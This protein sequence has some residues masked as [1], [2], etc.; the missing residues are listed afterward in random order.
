MLVADG[1]GQRKMHEWIGGRV[2]RGIINYEEFRSVGGLD[3]IVNHNPL[4]DGGIRCHRPLS[5]L[6]SNGINNGAT[7]KLCLLLS[8][9]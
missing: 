7:C 3:C 1:P 4:C 2:R 6:V 8:D 9:D 5:A